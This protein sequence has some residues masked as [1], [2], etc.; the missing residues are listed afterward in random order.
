MLL[1]IEKACKYVIYNCLKK[2]NIYIYTLNLI[3]LFYSY[4]CNMYSCWTEV[5][6]G[7]G[8][9]VQ[10]IYV[11][12][13]YLPLVVVPEPRQ[14]LLSVTSGSR[15]HQAMQS[16]FHLPLCWVLVF[17]IHLPSSCCRM[18]EAAPED[19][20]KIWSFLLGWSCSPD[21]LPETTSDTSLS[22]GD[23][24]GSCTS[25]GFLFCFIYSK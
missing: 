3:Y 14:W 4:M 25:S 22:A 5:W 6:P 11:F 17:V 8:L 24:E 23:K 7:I 16:P 19:G 1:K 2:K 20:R 12:N 15:C 21:K 9:S 13:Q 18:P 10:S